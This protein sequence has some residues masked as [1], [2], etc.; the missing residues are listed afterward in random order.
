M[1]LIYRLVSAAFGLVLLVA[2]ASK[3]YDIPAFRESLEHWSTVPWFLREFVSLSVPL[4]ESALGLM[5]VLRIR[6]RAALICG[7]A[8]LAAIT[9]AIIIQLLRGEMVGCR[10]F[11]TMLV[12]RETQDSASWMLWRNG[13]L[14]A[15]AVFAIL[16]HR[17]SERAPQAKAEAVSR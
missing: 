6:E 3:V 7:A 16:M 13:V 12:F 17:R 8:L 14:L 15:M 2:G 11:G 10:C 9:S 4:A 5:I 1:R